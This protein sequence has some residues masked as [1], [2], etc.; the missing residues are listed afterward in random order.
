M[1]ITKEK[2]QDLISAYLDNEASLADAQLL[3]D[4]IKADK[5][6]Y[7]FFL[8]S[9]AMHKTMCSVYGKK[10]KFPPLADFDVEKLLTTKKEATLRTFVEWTIVA[11]LFLTSVGLL[12]LLVYTKENK[13]TSQEQE[14]ESEKVLN[15]YNTELCEK[16][17]CQDGDVGI[18]KVE[19][20]HSFI[21]P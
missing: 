5:R 17:N 6:L 4:C 10:A 16:V 15:N 12:F 13:Q 14:V 11:C 3:L 7:S 9:C 18:I 20:K 21:A 2:F 19:L 8:R 1:K